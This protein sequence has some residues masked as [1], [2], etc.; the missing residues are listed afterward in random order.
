MP[1]ESR[2]QTARNHTRVLE[3]ASRLVRERGAE[4]TIPEVMAAAGMVP[5]G[6]YKHFASK[7]DLLAQAGAAAFDSRLRV[8][9]ELADTAVDR[10]DAFER[11]LSDYLSVDHRD[12]PGRGC[13][14]VALAADATHRVAD[15]PLHRTYIA[16][17]RAMADGL[18]ALRGDPDRA[19]PA[20]PPDERTDPSPESLAELA[21]MV[22]AVVLAR[23]TAGDDISERILDAARQHLLD[24]RRRS[25][26]E[27]E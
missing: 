20:D 25:G 17:T 4:V 15:D 12:N 24:D 11:F 10:G 27:R 19:D 1:R 21:T 14:S 22:G 2:E 16:G 8:L 18:D 23:A 13:A 3:E 6:F 5:G 7:D 9:C 26:T